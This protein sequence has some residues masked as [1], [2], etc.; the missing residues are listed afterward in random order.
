MRVKSN[1]K[2]LLLKIVQKI[3]LVTLQMVAVVSTLNARTTIT[4]YESNH[5]VLTN[6]F[7]ITSFF[8]HVPLAENFQICIDALYS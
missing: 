4:H 6:A 1:W 7:E 3:A 2:L 8:T 5:K